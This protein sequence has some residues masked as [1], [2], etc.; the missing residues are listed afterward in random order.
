MK[1]ARWTAHLPRM[2]VVI[3]DIFMVWAAWQLLHMAR[4]AISPVAHG[5]SWFSADLFKVLCIQTAV[6]WWSGLYKG[7]WRFASVADLGNIFRASFVGAVIIILVLAWSRFAGVPLSVLALY[8]VVLAALLGMSRLLYRAW[9]DYRSARSHAGGDR[10]LILGAGDVASTLIRDLHRMGQ[11]IPI[12]LVDD[13]PHLKGA[14]LMGIPVLG[15]LEQA[16]DIARETA[17]SLL[18]IAIPSLQKEAFQRIVGICERTGLPYRI[19]P[20]FD[21]AVSG[22]VMQLKELA[23]EDLLGRQP[24]QPDW[25]AIRQWLGGRTVLV[26]GAGGSI[27]SELCRQCAR[28]GAVRLIVI[29]QSELSLLTVEKEL[30]FR[31]P[32]VDVCP[33]LGDCGDRALMEY[34]L[35]KWGA[36]AI[37]HAAA[38]KHVPVLEEQVREAIRNNV[39]ASQTVAEAAVAFAVPHFVLISTDKA[40]NPINA[41]GAS[42]RCAEMICQGL[43]QVQSNTRFVTVRF[44]N[45]LDSAGSVVPIFREQI[46]K[47]GPVTVTDPAVT[48]YFMTIPESCQLILQA[49]SASGRAGVYTLDMGEPVLIVKLA[50]QMIRLAGKIPGK[51]V[52]IVFTGLRPGEKLHETLFYSDERHVPT[53]H[54][55]VMEAALRPLAKENLMNSLRQMADASRRY[56]CDSLKKLLGQLVPEYA[57]AAQVAPESAVQSRKVVPFSARAGRTQDGASAG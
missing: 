39:L 56:D 26:T 40:V 37:F 12:G 29:D 51:D 54:P 20:S 45:V 43:G 22:S 35:G 9:S 48:R 57:S 23:I 13:A 55:K 42:K 3:H 25:H 34:A 44:G 19:A 17:A 47:G 33:V 50:E 52:S 41:L 32:T 49:V 11:Y 30:R 1:A 10:I 4:F 36:D 21:D 15:T 28:N 27:G 38:Y 53:S 6:F 18:V 24:V 2:A 8:P 16:P 7:L 46:Q 14:K 5:I 31:Y